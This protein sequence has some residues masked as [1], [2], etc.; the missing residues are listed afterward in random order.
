MQRFWL[1]IAA[2]ALVG[3]IVPTV[4]QSDQTSET[5]VTFIVHP[6]LA[7]PPG[8][9]LLDNPKIRDHGA[10]MVKL[11]ADGKL[12]R[13]GPFLDG[14]GGIGI[15]AKGVT[16]EEMTKLLAEDPAA[17]SGVVTFEIKPWLVAV[18]EP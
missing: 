14:S 11:H 17:K 7:N 15:A 4:A 10:Y 2:I 5:R 18:G 1:S 13:G 16:I 9:S 3:T 8:T 6:G 12:A